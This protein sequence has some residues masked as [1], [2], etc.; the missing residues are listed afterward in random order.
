MFLLEFLGNQRG[1][2]PF[3]IIRISRKPITRKALHNFQSNL[4][5]GA[6]KMAEAPE[7]PAKSLSTT[8]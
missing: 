2:K 8:F 5:I 6:E 7:S 1:G 3:I 4:T